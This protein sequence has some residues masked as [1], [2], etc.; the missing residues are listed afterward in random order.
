MHLS[1]NYR[2]VYDGFRM[3]ICLGT[4]DGG[5]VSSILAGHGTL[6]D[7]NSVCFMPSG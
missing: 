1:C 2:G 3:D 4:E 7:A 6:V 5:A